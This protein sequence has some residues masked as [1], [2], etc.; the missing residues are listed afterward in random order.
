MKKFLLILCTAASFAAAQAQTCV[1]DSSVLLNDSV[2]VSPLPYSDNY[3]VYALAHACIGQPYQQSFTLRVPSSFSFQGIT[4][5]ITSASLPTT[6]AL[7]GQPA[8]ITYLCDPPNCVFNVNTLGCIL[9][10]GTPTAANTPETFDLMITASIQTQFAPVPITFPG[11][12]APGNYYL[13]LDAADNC[14]SSAYE[15]NSQ[16][17]GIKNQP[18]PFGQQ[19]TIDVESVVIGDFQFE[20]FNLLGKRMH[21]Q[22]VHLFT[23]NNQFTFDAGNMADGTYFYSLSNRDGKL[24]KVMVIAR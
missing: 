13:I 11:A 19:T 21:Q 17:V 7:S 3:Q 5:P 10:Y 4:L 9:L 8:G 15:R 1:R 2:I 18:N 22:T 14:V 12:V 16:I 23:G 24:T 20:V 6:G